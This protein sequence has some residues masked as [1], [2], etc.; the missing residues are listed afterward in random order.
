MPG[1]N[2]IS[3]NSNTD[4]L[5]KLKK[6]INIGFHTFSCSSYGHYTKSTSC[7]KGWTENASDKMSIRS[8]FNTPRTE[9]SGDL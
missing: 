8:L 5:N 4:N 6:H 7:N 1:T 2:A 3:L 9:H